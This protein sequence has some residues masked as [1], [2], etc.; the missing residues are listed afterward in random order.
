MRTF[1]ER[2]G[3]WAVVAGGSEGI[4]ASFSRSLAEEG[5]NVVI[6]ARHP[7]P[8]GAFAS[9]LRERHDVEVEPH[10]LDLGAPGLIDRIER[11]TG[12]L[13]VGL[14]VY[15]AAHSPIG[16]FLDVDLEDHLEAIRV[17]VQGPLQVAY[18]FGPRLA[19]RGR[20]GIIL[21]SSMSSYQGTAMV[22]NYA[23]TKA[24]NRILAEGLWHELDEV[25][26]DV[27]ACVAG[28]TTTPTFLKST[29]RLPRRWLARPMQPDEVAS[30][31]LRDLGRRPAGVSGRRNRFGATLL[32]RILPR[33]QA[34]RMVSD[35]TEYMYR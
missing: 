35:E 28:A 1:H 11:V 5:L 20:G 19:A 14:V 21:M 32:T 4:G 12:H 6:L 18:H 22:A 26:V 31:A 2:Y 29:D 8:L 33:R 27:L 23:A 34:I 10:V 9:E 13:D 17:N 16:R 7:E 3:P 15:N 24:Y 25:G 30:Q